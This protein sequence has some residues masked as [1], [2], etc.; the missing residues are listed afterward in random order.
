MEYEAHCASPKGCVAVRHLTLLALALAACA[1]PGMP[2]GGPPDTEAPR[3]VR[4]LPDSNARN[5][6]RSTIVVEF[7]EVVSERPRGA[8]ALGD[9]FILSPSSGPAAVSWKR[10]R[11]ELIPRGGLRANT[12]YTLRLLPGLTD[13]AGNSDS[14]GLEIVFS[15]GPEI[16]SAAIVGRVFDWLAARPAPSAY[17]EAVSLPDSARYATQADSSGYFAIRHMEPGR[18]LL[19]AILDQNRNRRVDPR[20]LFD[21]VTVELRDSLHRELL[22]AVRDSLGPGIATVEPQDSLRLRVTLDRPVDTAFVFG[23][24]AF[25]LKDADSATIPIREVL[26][27]AEWERRLADSIARADSARPDS[28]R[29][30]D[31]ARAT[32]GR[33]P[34]G[35]GSTPPRPNAAVPATVLYI[36]LERPLVPASSYRL[37]AVGL[38]SIS[39]ATRTSE[40]QFATPRPRTRPDTTSSRDTAGRSIPRS[41]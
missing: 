22:A 31:T 19:R 34:A 24:G 35:R 26:T 8:A 23:P 32:P 4:V 2:P 36:L 38:R 10:T 27:Q 33:Q 6:R 14:T 11:I 13:L 17:I 7:D 25:L 15:T 1:Q 12:T 20:E 30:A 3:V 9:L 18:Y 16:A 40:R 41:R 28:L 5:V 21:S 37:R 29:R 39:G